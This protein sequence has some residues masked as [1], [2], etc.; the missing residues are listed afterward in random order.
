MITCCE[1]AI[2]L[3]ITNIVSLAIFAGY[4][5]K[6]SRRTLKLE[7]KNGKELHEI[8]KLNQKLADLEKKYSERNKILLVFIRS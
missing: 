7:K 5:L 3:A 6:V 2:T 4:T 1:I 8:E